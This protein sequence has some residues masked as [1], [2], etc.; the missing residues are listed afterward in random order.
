MKRKP[1]IFKLRADASHVHVYFLLFLTTI[2]VGRAKKISYY[3]TWTLFTL[4]QKEMEDK[5][6][7]RI[8]LHQANNVRA[9]VVHR[10]QRPKVNKQII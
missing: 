4:L 1:T 6:N 2:W 8:Y 9:H 10:L 7:Q 3:C 5:L